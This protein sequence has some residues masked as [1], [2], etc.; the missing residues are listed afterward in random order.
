MAA[1][2]ASIASAQAAP[3]AP[4]LA[5]MEFLVGHWSSGT[6]KVT[7]THGTARGSSRI[8]VEAGGGVLLRRDHT[9]LFD[10]QG[11]P[12]GGMDQIMMI[13]A[14]GGTVRADYSDGAHVIHY[15]SAE[16]TA[17]H[18]VV[19]TSAAGGAAP[20]FRLSYELK[21][22]GTLAISFAMAPPGQSEFHEIAAGTAYKD[23]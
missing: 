8:T 22:S 12:A 18:S 9:E 11:K 5:G 16:I 21:P 20:T 15:T 3:L 17:G 4:D 19:F 23:K 1:V 10:A 6:G 2:L 14:D 7:D 13:Y